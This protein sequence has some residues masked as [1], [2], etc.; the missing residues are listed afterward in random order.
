MAKIYKNLTELIGRT[1]LVEV[2]EIEREDGL[3]ARV[4]V[5]LESYNPAGSA[6]DRVALAMIEDAERRGILNPGATIIEPTSGNTGIGLAWVAGLRGYKCV[7]TMP[8]TMSVERRN[9]LKALGAKLVLTPGKDGMNGAIAKAR[10]LHE[11]T[12]GSFIP[13][14]FNNPVNAVAHEHTTA[15]EIW[16]DTDGE[17]DIVVAGVGTGGTL[18][19][20]AKRLKSLKKS[21]KAIAVEPSDSPV[22]SGGKPGPHKLQGIGAGFVPGNYC[23]DLVDEI[24]TVTFDDAFSAARRL[25]SREGILAG[26]SSGAAFWAAVEVARR[27]ENAGKTIVAVLPDTGQRYLSTPLF[28][29]DS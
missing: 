8:E 13:D 22:L 3:K 12:P 6:K 21:V 5:K 28:A 1:P 15:M 19:G 27:P 26:I 20:T 17:V 16:E 25:A 18:C 24:I 23:A 7:L 2:C 9:L 29:Y 10:E 11:Q 4:L 14:Q